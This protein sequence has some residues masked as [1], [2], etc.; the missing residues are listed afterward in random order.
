MNEQISSVL[1]TKDANNKYETRLI[2]PFVSKR[3]CMK[4]SKKR[5]RINS[6]ILDRMGG[7]FVLD[8]LV[9]HFATGIVGDRHLVPVFGMFT[10]EELVPM[11]RDLMGYALDDSF[12]MEFN[13]NKVHKS[14]ELKKLCRLG[15]MDETMYFDRMALHLLGSMRLCSFKETRTVLQVGDRFRCLRVA[16][17]QV[18][19]RIALR[20]TILPVT[21]FAFFWSGVSQCTRQSHHAVDSE[22]S[23]A[24]S[25][26]VFSV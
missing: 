17:Q 1:I 7:E 10:L 20:K 19:E 26:E 11:L 18:A 15:L 6:K 3:E 21:I 14:K 23:G 8:A 22:L 4:V 2:Y 25:E 13:T 12:E 16:L 5:K 9:M 24:G